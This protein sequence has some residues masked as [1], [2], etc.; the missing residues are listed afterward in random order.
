MEGI[1]LSTPVKEWSIK[2]DA[3]VSQ[4]SKE[5]EENMP[6]QDAL[7]KAKTDF[8]RETILELFDF[9]VLQ[10]RIAGCIRYFHIN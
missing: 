5:V 1:V 8:Q 3:S 6:R 2:S 7:K 10:Y 9:K 4:F